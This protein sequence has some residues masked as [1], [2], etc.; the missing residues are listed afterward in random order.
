MN[1]LIGL[2]ILS[3]VV[4]SPAGTMSAGSWRCS[5]L[6]SLLVAPRQSLGNS[7][8]WRG[9]EQ[10]VTHCV[11]APAPVELPP[12]ACS[13]ALSAPQLCNGNDRLSP[14]MQG[15]NGIHYTL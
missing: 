2:I 8:A 6:E 4:S 10:P 11:H 15:A 9:V 3:G 12:G 5:R 7:L 13:G 14:H 1:N